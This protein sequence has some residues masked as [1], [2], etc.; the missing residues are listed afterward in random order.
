MEE[1]A[2]NGERKGGWKRWLPMAG[3]LLIFIPLQT[4]DVQTACLVAGQVL[5]SMI[6]TK[7]VSSWFQG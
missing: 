6:K 3:V 1:V 4:G 2:S 7:V 5:P